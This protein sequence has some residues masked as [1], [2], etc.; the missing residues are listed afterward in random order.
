ML[1]Q[2]KTIAVATFVFAGLALSTSA[3]FAAGRHHFDVAP[4]KISKSFGK[5]PKRRNVRHH[6]DTRPI[7][8]GKNFGPRG[9]EGRGGFGLGR[10]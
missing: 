9:N 6:F 7:R 10:N 1:K 4:K 2:I 8:R 3:S 5:G